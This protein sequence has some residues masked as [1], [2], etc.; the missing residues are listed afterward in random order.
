MVGKGPSIA[1]PSSALAFPELMGRV[2]VLGGNAQVKTAFLVGLALRHIQKHGV[3]L[4]F[5]ARHHQPLE[6]HFRLRFRHAQCHFLISQT[7]FLPPTLAQMALSTVSRSLASRPPRPAPLLLLDGIQGSVDW[8]R[9][10]AFLLK[11]GA[12]VVE[13]LRSPGTL[14]FGC[15]DTE[16]LLQEKTALADEISRAVG[17]KVDPH[18]LA[19][20]AETEGIL[21]HRTQQY[22]VLL[23]LAT[24]AE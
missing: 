14:P 1:P 9:L 8:E 19:D 13:T 17:R 2:A 18:A 10:I 23:P 5:D 15:Y 24:T 21:L 16:L 11:S 7:E 6:V 22:R 3:V 4:C 20:L 12:T